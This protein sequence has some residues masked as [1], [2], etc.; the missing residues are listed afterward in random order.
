MDTLIACP[1]CTGFSRLVAKNHLRD[2]PRNSLVAR[3]AEYAAYFQPRVIFMENARELLRGRFS[4]HYGRLRESLESMGY[5]VRGDVHMLTRFGLPQQRERSVVLAVRDGAPL[6]G[7]EDLWRGL[8]VDEKA[9]HVRRAIWD[10]PPIE[11]GQTLDADPAHYVFRAPALLSGS[12]PL[13]ARRP[14]GR[15]HLRSLRSLR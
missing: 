9:T 8:M 4:H 13:V 5:R 11:S 6:P 10:L 2:D 14:G 1:P 7:L 3:V 15:L 12:Q